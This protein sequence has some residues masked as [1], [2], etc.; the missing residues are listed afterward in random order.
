MVSVVIAAHN[1]EAV[2]GACLD[3]LRNQVA[4]GP[5]DIVVSANGCTDGT[6][7]V[8]REGGAR[9][10]ERPEPGKAGALNAG[11]A[12][13]RGYPRIYLD[14]DI[15]PS[16][17]AVDALVSE[18]EL[19]QALA[20][21]PRRRLDTTARPWP[22]KAYFAVNERLPA[23]RD[24]LFGRGMIAL[25]AEG[26]ARFAQFPPLIADDLFLDAQFSSAEKC[27]ASGA[28]VVVETPRTTRDLVR[29]LVR[30]RRG[31]A[32]L[33]DASAQVGVRVRDADRT[34]WLREVARDPRL[35]PAA[36]P[37]VV[38]TVVAAV[39]ARRASRPTAA[40]GRDESTRVQAV[41]PGAGTR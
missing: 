31:N 28:M 29:R 4:V 41:A 20:V 16:P 35:L 18:L 9:V 8:A 3:S 32:E 10:V 12:I 38:I 24:G 40:W 26:R 15:V 11:D 34:A 27:E 36:V 17:G 22:V 13:A 1:E 19:G 6:A 23:F 21:V 5:I 39:L 33:R 30:V 25:S 14:A 37:Y 2:L 7:R